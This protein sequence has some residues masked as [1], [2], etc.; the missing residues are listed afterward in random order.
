MCDNNDLF[1]VGD[2]RR[3][4]IRVVSGV[5]DSEAPRRVVLGWRTPLQ[6]LIV[7]RGF[8]SREA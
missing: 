1:L 7:G 2:L 6:T 3:V 4:S 8:P 5:F